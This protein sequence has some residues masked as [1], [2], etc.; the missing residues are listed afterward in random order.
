V[1]VVTTLVVDLLAD[2]VALRVRVAG[3]RLDVATIALER[4]ETGE[5]G[6]AA[7][8]LRDLEPDAVL[9]ATAAL[10]RA[11]AGTAPLDGALVLV[12]GGRCDVSA[13]LGRALGVPACLADL[14]EV[15]RL[16]HELVEGRVVVRDASDESFDPLGA[17]AGAVVD[18]RVAPLP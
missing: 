8:A 12:E 16:G 11:L 3:D 15:L 9:R 14:V 7:R 6:V 4:P 10:Q 5:A 2:G 18:G 17:A 13:P 1:P